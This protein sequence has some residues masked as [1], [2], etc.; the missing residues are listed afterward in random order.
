MARRPLAYAGRSSDDDETASRASLRLDSDDSTSVDLQTDV[1][2]VTD[3]DVPPPTCRRGK[4]RTRQSCS[5]QRFSGKKSHKSKKGSHSL[6]RLETDLDCCS[7][8]ND[9]NIDTRCS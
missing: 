3:S 8:N 1:T 7:S 5:R 4:D 9:V 6:S 2:D